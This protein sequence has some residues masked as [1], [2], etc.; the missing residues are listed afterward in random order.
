LEHPSQH[1]L[2]WGYQALQSFLR[3]AYGHGIIIRE[4]QVNRGSRRPGCD[5][6]FSLPVVDDHACRVVPGGQLREEGAVSGAPS[7][8]RWMNRAAPH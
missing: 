2:C 7:D 3:D 6:A 8:S 4:V 1:T 5:L